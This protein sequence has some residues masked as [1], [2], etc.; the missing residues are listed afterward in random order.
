MDSITISSMGD[1]R[2]S[3]LPNS[4]IIHILSF[5]PTKD[6]VTTCLLSKRWKL[7]WYSVPTIFFSNN[8]SHRLISVVEWKHNRKKFYNY[9]EKYL[10]HRKK[11][12]YFIVDSVI[13]SFNLNMKGTYQ[14]SKTHILD[15]WL[16]FAVENKIKELYL[17]IGRAYNNGDNIESFY[18]LPKI[19]DNARFLTILELNAVRLDTT[20]HL[21]SF[22][23]LK[24]LSLER[25]QQSNT[26]KDHDVVFKFLLG[27]P[28]LEKLRLHNY[29]FLCGDDKPPLQSLSLEVLELI[30][31]ENVNGLQVEAVNLESLILS[32]VSV[33][34]INLSSCEKIRN[35]S[36]NDT[37]DVFQLSLNAL[38]SKIPQ[39]EN[40]TLNTWY[41]Y[42]P[43]DDPLRISGQ[44]LKSFNFK[45]C[46]FEPCNIT[47]ESAPKLEY[48]CYEGCLDLS[49]SIEP[50]NSLS[51]KI[52]IS[53]ED[54]GYDTTWYIDMM[55]F[56]LNLNCSWNTL[57][58]HI[59]EYEALIWPKK[60]KRVCRSPL[61]NWKHL[62]VITNDSNP[63]RISDLKN[64]LMWISPSLETLFI[65]NK[66]IF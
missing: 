63:E 34:N 33:C 3:K 56:L 30:D 55:N 37:S 48:F 13:T 45:N 11:G 27:C 19:I 57:T 42:D 58:L 62:R 52:V 16:A 10:E 15:K 22:P 46:H 35:L 51:G 53:K 39:L 50:S 21:F 43:Y 1:D 23:S 41:A 65:D 6:V 18:C 61:L 17:S 66:Q 32:G 5:L 24:T 59:K 26:S 8:I 7:I 4:L 2:F 31:T 29:E 38:I 40:F 36:V 12:M 64:S 25:I 9:V 14:R 44:W 54:D 28:S 47:I 20:S 49:I 60:L